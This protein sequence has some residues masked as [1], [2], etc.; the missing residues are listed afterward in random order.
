M[1]NIKHNTGGNQMNTF[2]PFLRM[3]TLELIPRIAIPK[4]IYGFRSKDFLIITIAT[5]F[6]VG[7]FVAAMAMW[8][9]VY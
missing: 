6:F 3:K 8:I 1:Q 7:P 5:A 2:M 9:T 4:K